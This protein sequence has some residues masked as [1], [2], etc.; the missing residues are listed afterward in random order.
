MWCSGRNRNFPRA[1]L[2]SLPPRMQGVKIVAT[3][4]VRICDSR[5][6]L[7]RQLLRFRFDIQSVREPIVYRMGTQFGVSTNI[8][9]ANVGREG[10]WVELELVGGDEDVASAVQ[11]ARQRGVV[12][13]EMAEE[14]GS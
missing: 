1:T 10:G 13:E 6:R 4:A 11:W 12:V 14:Q 3:R 9:R 5:A 2:A 8:V 7:D